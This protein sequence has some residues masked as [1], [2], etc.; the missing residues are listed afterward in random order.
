MKLTLHWELFDCLFFIIKI[1]ENKIWLAQTQKPAK[2]PASAFCWWLCMC[3]L[4]HISQI[5]KKL[6]LSLSPRLCISQ[7]FSLYMWDILYTYSNNQACCTERRTL[8]EPAVMCQTNVLG[9]TFSR[10]VLEVEE[11]WQAFLIPVTTRRGSQSSVSRTLRVY[12]RTKNQTCLQ[13][14]GFSQCD[15]STW[16]IVFH[17]VMHTWSQLQ[18]FKLYNCK[19]KNAFS[20]NIYLIHNIFVFMMTFC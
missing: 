1:L 11:R 7:L 6:Y 19:I 12:L 15:S 16:Q 8:L 5:F 17:G 14:R 4:R 13:S 10:C 9:L 2:H 20:H 3:L 18:D